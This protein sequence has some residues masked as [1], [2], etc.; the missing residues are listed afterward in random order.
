MQPVSRK[1][2]A[3]TVRVEP[4]RDIVNVLEIPFLSHYVIFTPTEK[5]KIAARTKI[6]FVFYHYYLE[7]Q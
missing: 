7:V 4:S 2:F 1:E 6:V 5:K 3:G